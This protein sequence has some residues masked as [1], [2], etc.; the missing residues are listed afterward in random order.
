M[1]F[2][3][4]LRRAS[5]AHITSS[6]RHLM[7]KVSEDE[8]LCAHNVDSA[9]NVPF[10]YCNADEDFANSYVNQNL[11]KN[12]ADIADNCDAEILFCSSSDIIDTPELA[13]N[14]RETT[15]L[16]TLCKEE[17]TC[18]VMSLYVINYKS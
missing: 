13:H 11:S 7:P 4:R 5:H 16:P 10:A 1:N 8:V 9:V 12:H 17:V 6:A 2:P 3:I 18:Q 15:D 14:S